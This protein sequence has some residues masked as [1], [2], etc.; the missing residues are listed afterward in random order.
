MLLALVAVAPIVVTVEAVRLC[1]CQ[2]GFNI[3]IQ[4]F[5][6]SSSLFVAASVRFR[7]WLPPTDVALTFG[8]IATELM[9]AGVIVCVSD[10]VNVCVRATS[11]VSNRCFGSNLSSKAGTCN[12]RT[13]SKRSRVHWPSWRACSSA[14]SVARPPC[15]SS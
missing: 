14:D 9:T 8:V 2:K 6:C 11:I 10:R 7:P 3:E 12:K 15:G 4:R 13:A 5:R 1:L